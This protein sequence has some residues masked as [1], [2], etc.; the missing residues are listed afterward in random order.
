[1]K[2]TNRLP[3]ELK[4]SSNDYT[5]SGLKSVLGAVPVAGSLLSEI[6]GTVIPNQRVDRIA[7]FARKLEL[8]VSHLEHSFFEREIKNEEFTDLVEESLRQAARAT[9]DDRREYLASLLATSL[10]SK[11]IEYAESHHLL[12]I[13][14]ELS[15]IEVIWLRF[16]SNPSLGGDDEF[17]DLHKDVLGPVEAAL[18]SD[19]N[20]IDKEA[21]QKSYKA[22]LERLG[23]ISGKV[24][25]DKNKNPEFDKLSG[26]F[27]R[28]S[29]RTTA[30]GGLLLRNIDLL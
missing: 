7:D 23:L 27:K 22:H 1:M 9:T 19:Q 10:N 11:D 14:S 4:P 30:L 6:A 28:Q 17:R 5:V 26:E 24:K 12:R 15:D 13:L 2:S 29:L 25:T 16:Y 20:E 21:L 8:R 3:D 18:G